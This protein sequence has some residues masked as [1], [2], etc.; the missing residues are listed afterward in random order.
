MLIALLT[1]ILFAC[2]SVSAKRSTTL[3]GPVQA[4]FM[5]MVFAM[6]VLGTATLCLAPVDLW[7]MAAQRFYV[8]GITGFAMGDMAAFLAFSRLGSRLTMI[9]CLCLAPVFGAAGD[10]FLLGTGLKWGHAFACVII[11]LGV[12]LSLLAKPGEAHKRSVLGIVAAVIAGL[13]MGLGAT[14]SRYAKAAELEQHTALTSYN[15]TT[16]RLL[17]AVIIVGLIWAISRYFVTNASALNKP[18]QPIRKAIPWVIANAT[19]GT[20]LGVTCFQW[21]L[22]NAPSGLVLSITATTPIFVMPLAAWL[23][24]DQLSR[25]SILG[26]IIAVIGVVFLRLA[27]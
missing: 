20:I 15:E 17:P 23:E 16:L 26:A 18:S 19:F 25:N 22:N 3:L 21:S 12:C 27:V 11:L 10:W 14:L 5:R 1:A 24:N 9:I 6:L 4:N 2:S 13:G 8:S 7:S